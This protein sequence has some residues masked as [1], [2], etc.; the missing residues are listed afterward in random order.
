MH[1]KYASILNI[2]FVTFMYGYC[3]PYL[4]PLAAF[5]MLVLYTSEKA[6]LYYVYRKPPSY[7]SQLSAA[8]IATA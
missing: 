6:C 7:D 5:A 4:F 1:Y 8:V 2:I 3:L